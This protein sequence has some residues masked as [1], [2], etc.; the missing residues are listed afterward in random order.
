MDVLDGIT[1]SGSPSTFYTNTTMG[2]TLSVSSTL[3]VTGV[4]TGGNGKALF[5]N[6]SA[7]SVSNSTNTILTFGSSYFNTFGS[8]LTYSGGVFTNA[9]GGVMYLYISYS[10]SWNTTSG[11]YGVQAWISYSGAGYRQGF[12]SV[13]VPNISGFL[14]T[15]P[16]GSGVLKLN[17]GDSFSIYGYQSSSGSI[18]T[19]V[20]T[21]NFT[22]LSVYQIP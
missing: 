22:L 15:N 10:F 4:I 8:S 7:Q 3:G 11:G 18:S 2:G 1:V 9:S 17:N 14:S 16:T 5:Y 13:N 6:S 12:F 21:S 19:V 20:N